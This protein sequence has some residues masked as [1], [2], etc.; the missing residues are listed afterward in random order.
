MNLDWRYKR[1]ECFDITKKKL[2]QFAFEGNDR[3]VYDNVNLSIFVGD[4]CNADCDFCVAKLRYANDGSEYLKPKIED[5]D[6]YL[7][8]V[9]YLLG[10]IRPLNPSVSI[11]GGEPTHYPERVVPIIKLLNK[12]NIRKRTITTNGTGL[13]FMYE[14]KTILE[15]L[16]D[17][18]FVH[19]NISKAHYDDE[20]NF[21]IM[22]Y[23][24][25]SLD[26][27][28]LGEIQKTLAGRAPRLRLSCVLLNNGVGT[29]PEMKKY[30]D[31]ALKHKV[32]NVV[33]RELMRYNMDTVNRESVIFNFCE[34]NRINLVD[35]WEQLDN[36]SNFSFLN[37]VLG[38]YYYVEVYNYN[39]IAMVSESANLKQI[40]LEK[41]SSTKKIGI[42]V[43]YEMVIHPNGSLNGSWREWE[44][45]LIAP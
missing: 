30:M 10:Q 21:K 3:F 42:P 27:E 32:D 33:F 23:D 34:R 28:F 37:Q 39:G 20:T 22:R 12:H 7:K 26:N 17:N 4:Y 36:D 31:V 40:Y 1:Q 16:I 38:Y 6:E 5:T 8:R 15:H 24:K 11:T 9:D 35:I 2:N 18:G 44:D 29:V 45:I 13:F 19:L 14:G 43:V 25:Y 41:E